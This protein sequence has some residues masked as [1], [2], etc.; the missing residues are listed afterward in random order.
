MVHWLY[1]QH[2]K[3]GGEAF[4]LAPSKKTS[5]WKLASKKSKHPILK[6]EHP[7]CEL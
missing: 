7:E 1:Q 3:E 2:P 4:I 5:R 6:P